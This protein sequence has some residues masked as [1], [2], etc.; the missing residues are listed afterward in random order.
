MAD[1]LKAAGKKG[2]GWV[3][4]IS[5]PSL[6]ANLP[7][8]QNA[9]ILASECRNISVRQELDEKELKTTTVRSYLG[10]DNSPMASGVQHFT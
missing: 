2:G 1:S 4:R 5:H 7:C 10:F 3:V 6:R 9:Q 8:V